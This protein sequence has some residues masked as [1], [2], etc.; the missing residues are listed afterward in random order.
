M[1]FLCASTLASTQILLHSTSERYPNGLGNE[2]GELGH[3]VMDHHHNVGAMGSFEGLQDKYYKGR[4]PS[5]IFIPKYVNY[6]FMCYHD[7][8]YYNIAA[9]K[10]YLMRSHTPMRIHLE[11][12]GVS[13][14]CLLGFTEEQKKYLGIE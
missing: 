9:I 13:D 4:K 8:K 5:G 10:L 3:N 14:S 12:L 11:I 1:I 2:S 6:I 7:I